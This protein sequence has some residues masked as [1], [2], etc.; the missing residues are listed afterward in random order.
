M[1][2]VLKNPSRKEV[3][4]FIKEN[5]PLRAAKDHSTRDIFVWP[6]EAALHGDVINALP[7]NGMVEALSGT[8]WNAND[9][10]KLK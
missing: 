9:L 8:I 6:G 1:V 5:G 10:A 4:K 7:Q 3:T 2:D